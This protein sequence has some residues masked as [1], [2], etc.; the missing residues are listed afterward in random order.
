[1]GFVTYALALALAARLGQVASSSGAGTRQSVQPFCSRFAQYFAARLL[2]MFVAEGA[3]C[4]T[5]QVLRSRSDALP[6]SCVPVPGTQSTTGASPP[7]SCASFAGPASIGGPVSVAGLASAS[8][9]D[10]AAPPDAPA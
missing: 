9:V 4:H 2:V 8:V 10:P 7:V 6:T 3:R 5:R 1:M